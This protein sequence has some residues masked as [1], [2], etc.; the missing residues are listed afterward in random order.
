MCVDALVPFLDDIL[1]LGLHGLD[2]LLVVPE[3]PLQLVD[4]LMQFIAIGL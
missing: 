4:P 3:L 1:E 2:P